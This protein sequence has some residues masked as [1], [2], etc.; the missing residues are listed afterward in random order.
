MPL[1]RAG[2]CRVR[3]PHSMPLLRAGFCHVRAA[4]TDGLRQTGLKYFSAFISFVLSRLIGN[5]PASIRYRFIRE[6][7]MRYSVSWEQ[8]MNAAKLYRFGYAIDQKNVVWKSD[9]I[10]S[11]AQFRHIAIDSIMDTDANQFQNIWLWTDVDQNA[12]F[13]PLFGN[14]GQ[15]FFKIVLTSQEDN[16]STNAP[17]RI[18]FRGLKLMSAVPSFP[19]PSAGGGWANCQILNF[20]FDKAEIEN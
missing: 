6:K 10:R 19:P 4:A 15:N 2:F 11:N 13:G 9:G 18:I 17:P 12:S 3:D 5:L 8:K 7:L 1:L 20:Y 16:V 14:V